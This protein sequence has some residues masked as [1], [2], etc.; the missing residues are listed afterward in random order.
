MFRE[1]AGAGFFIWREKTVTCLKPKPWVGGGNRLPIYGRIFHMGSVMTTNTTF[2]VNL[3]AHFLLISQ[4]VVGSI[5]WNLTY[6][7][8]KTIAETVMFVPAIFNCVVL[9]IWLFADNECRVHI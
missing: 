5:Q 1:R 7:K 4:R 3:Q 8:G 2:K 9:G 6:C